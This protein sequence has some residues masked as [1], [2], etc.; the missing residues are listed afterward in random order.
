[1]ILF[2]F[3]ESTATKITRTAILGEQLV[4]VDSQHI[5]HELFDDG[6]EELIQP[7][8]HRRLK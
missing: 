2:R 1:M 5:C 7:S 4:D 8:S 3:L 6:H